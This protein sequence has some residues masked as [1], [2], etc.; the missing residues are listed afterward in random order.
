MAGAFQMLRSNDLI[1][2]RTIREYLLG[3]RGGMNDLMAWNA[4]ATRMP[5]RMHA[6]YLRK[7]FLENRLALGQFSVGGR[8]ISLED[9]EV[10]VF[11]VGTERDHVAPWR[12]A[13]KITRFADGPNTFVLTSG[14]HNAGIVSEPG[15]PRRHYRVGRCPAMPPT[16]SSGSRRM[17]FAEGSWWPE[18]SGWLARHSTD[19]RVAEPAP[20]P[21]L[22]AAP[23]RYVFG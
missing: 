20:L 13:W 18:W 14:G 9:I 12:S 15:H 8:P 3:E 23:G 10:P 6:E 21:S 17:R 5:A 2:S 11:A 19:R 1:W 4:D 7:L 22:G 16:P